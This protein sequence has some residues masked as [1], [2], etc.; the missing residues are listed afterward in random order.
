MLYL[1]WLMIERDGDWKSL[2]WED[3]DEP[4]WTLGDL[5]Y[6]VNYVHCTDPKIWFMIV[7]NTTLGLIGAV[8]FSKIDG[9]E[10]EGNIWMAKGHRHKAREVVRL[11]TAEGFRQ[12]FRVI[13][14]TTPHRSVV[15]LLVKCGYEDLGSYEGVWMLRKA[16][17]HG[18]IIGAEDSNLAG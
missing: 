7:D 18:Q 4:D 6:F 13:H 5:P 9:A 12:G 15:N 2:F 14:G 17:D 10:C 1:L 8:W 11:A 16:N 3:K